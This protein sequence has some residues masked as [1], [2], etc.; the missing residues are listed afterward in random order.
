MKLHVDTPDDFYVM[1]ISNTIV[2]Y[3]SGQSKIFVIEEKC[4]VADFVVDLYAF[5]KYNFVGRDYLFIHFVNGPEL[6]YSSASAIHEAERAHVNAF[7]KWPRT[8]RLKVPNILTVFISVWP[9][10]IETLNLSAQNGRPWQGGEIHTT[11]FIELKGKHYTGP[12]QNTV[13]VKGGRFTFKET[14]PQNRALHLINNLAKQL[15]R[16]ETMGY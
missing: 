10:T 3:L 12:G 7:Y 16:E 14:D 9:F 8:L 1:D 6:D 2:T 11:H 13:H 5:R 15:F 4:N